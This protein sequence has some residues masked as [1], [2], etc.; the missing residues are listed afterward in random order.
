VTKT[1]GPAVTEEQ[2][3]Q[4]D[5]LL[6]SPTITRTTSMTAA[7]LLPSPPASC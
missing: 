6:V 1:I 4:V 7:V 2:L 5:L 3:G